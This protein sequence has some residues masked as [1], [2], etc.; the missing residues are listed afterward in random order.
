MLDQKITPFYPLIINDTPRVQAP[1]KKR[2]RF[3]ELSRFKEE[4]DHHHDHTFE[5]HQSN[6]TKYRTIFWSMGFLF[7]SLMAAILMQNPVWFEI[8]QT[9]FI[10]TKAG[11][12]SLCAIL[13]L[14]AFFLGGVIRAEKEAVTYVLQQAR[15]KLSQDYAHQRMRLGMHRFLLFCDEYLHA[16]SLRYTYQRTLSQ[17]HEKKNKTLRLMQRIRNTKQ[18]DRFSRMKLLNQALLELKEQLNAVVEGFHVV[19]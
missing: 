2:S 4:I 19:G 9:M 17:L 15:H 8:Y 11:I 14:A 7:L 3:E 18:L 12:A 6:A 16:T 10:L 5:T 1:W 13:A